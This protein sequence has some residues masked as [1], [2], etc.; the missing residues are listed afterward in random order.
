MEIKLTGI[1]DVDE[2]ALNLCNTI[3]TL[4]KYT[5]VSKY[6]K[7]LLDL[8]EGIRTSYYEDSKRNNYAFATDMKVDYA[9]NSAS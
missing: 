5:D 9:K 6:E 7:A 4:S 1:K 8:L 2:K 3:N